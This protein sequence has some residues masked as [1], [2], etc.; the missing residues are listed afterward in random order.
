MLSAPLRTRF[1]LSLR[2]DYYEPE[3]LQQIVQRSADILNV[4]IEPEGAFEIARRSRGTPRI[5][6][7][8]LRWTR[9]YAQVKAKGI[10]NKETAAS[11]LSMLDIDDCG[12]DEMDKRILETILVRFRGGPVGLNSLSVAIGEE[13]DTIE[14]V[15]EPYLIQEGYMMRTAQGRIAT[16]KAWSMFGL[17]PR[18]KR[19][20]GAPSDTPDLL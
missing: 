10:V 3:H 4:E 17:T 6:N 16:E 15:Y 1:S 11:A 8:L 13:A 5:A 2:L 19:S 18:G 20:R 7:N 12:L 9:D 14:D